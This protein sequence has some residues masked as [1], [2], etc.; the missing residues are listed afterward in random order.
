M[1]AF[2]DVHQQQSARRRMPVQRDDLTLQ[3]GK[4][5]VEASS[6]DWIPNQRPGESRGLGVGEQAAVTGLLR[7][8]HRANRGVD[9]IRQ[10]AD[11]L[12]GRGLQHRDREASRSRIMVGCLERHE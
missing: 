3:I 8:S 9:A 2:V 1:H 6:T 12:T 10:G 5:D 11:D 4:G 7:E